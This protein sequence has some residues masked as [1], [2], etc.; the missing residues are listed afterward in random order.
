MF[1]KDI[2][3][4]TDYNAEKLKNYSGLLTISDIKKS[5]VHK[6]IL[7]YI[8]A[9]FEQQ[10]YLDKQKLI[11]NSIFEYNNERINNYFDL[12]SENII[13]TN[14]FK[15]EYLKKIIQNG[16]TFNI[17]FLIAPNKTL[18]QLVFGETTKKPISEIN[19]S[20][21]HIYY[22]KHFRK[23]ITAITEKKHLDSITKN[24]FIKLLKKIDDIS[25]G[26]HLTDMINTAINSMADFFSTVTPNQI[27]VQALYLFLQGKKLPAHYNTVKSEYLDKSISTAPVKEIKELLANIKHDETIKTI[28]NNKEDIIEELEPNNINNITDFAED[29]HIPNEELLST[30]K[31]I[32]AGMENLTSNIIFDM[33]N[34]TK[35]FDINTEKDKTPN[36]REFENIKSE[37]TT[38]QTQQNENEKPEPKNM[39]NSLIDIDNLFNS[40]L[41]EDKLPDE[42]NKITDTNNFLESLSNTVD[43]QFDKSTLE[44][45]LIGS[46]NISEDD[47]EMEL[48]ETEKQPEKEL[49]LKES[50]NL[51]QAE[52]TE[53][54][55][56]QVDEYINKLK[57]KTTS[58]TETDKTTNNKILKNENNSEEQLP[59]Q[60]LKEDIT[61]SENNNEEIE[62]VFTDLSYLT[63]EDIDEE[64]TK[65]ITETKTD[66]NKTTDPTPVNTENKIQKETLENKENIFDNN[67]ESN[68]LTKTEIVSDKKVLTPVSTLKEIIAKENMSSIIETIFDYDMEDYQKILNKISETKTSR[69][70]IN[71]INDYCKQNYL[72]L[73]NPEVQ[74]FKAIISGYFNK[75]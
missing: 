37:E 5:D 56:K 13:R 71:I 20:L 60:T 6:S 58:D 54:K 7:K 52:K 12:I 18:T 62:E 11:H 14:K 19:L 73:T 30:G 34:L 53:E 63:K 35:D 15:F 33:K 16:V 51:L 31:N 57:N 65:E 70:A 49:P 36:N 28:P 8:L 10:L 75:K 64:P 29:E 48:M 68:I 3:L 66:K 55:I 22:Y 38:G 9:E 2:Q 72:N 32:S 21:S 39:L 69:K 42:K 4:I 46:E 25:K 67:L 41:P 24:D 74:K 45:T 44:Q 26:S 17:H 40:L 43:F 1:K 23:I 59:E 27:S 50:N 47:F 61:L